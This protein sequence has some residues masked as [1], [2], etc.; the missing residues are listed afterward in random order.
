V[1]GKI[2]SVC[3]DISKIAAKETETKMR[4]EK[5]ISLKA[6]ML[7][8]VLIGVETIKMAVFHAK[9]LSPV[10]FITVG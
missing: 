2:L 1:Y 7:Y 10:K 6:L 4:K 5:N 3:E 9:E 8:A